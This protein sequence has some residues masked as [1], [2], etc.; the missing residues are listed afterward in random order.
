MIHKKVLPQSSKRSKTFTKNGNG[1]IMLKIVVLLFCI[2]FGAP[3]MAKENAFTLESLSFKNGDPLAVRHAYNAGRCRGLGENA[4]PELHWKGAP[5]ETKSFA[6][7]SHDPDAPVENGW[8]HWILTDIPADVSALAEGITPYG[9][10]K[11]IRNSFGIY[12]YGGPCPPSGTH[13]Y[14]FTVYAIGVDSLG[15]NEDTPPADAERIIRANALASASI[16]GMFSA[17]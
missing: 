5:S 16:V 4:S 17:R 8:Y 1:H 3:A 2:T 15:L 12:S 11:E 13:R 7:I 9:G 14:Y 6:V 10:M